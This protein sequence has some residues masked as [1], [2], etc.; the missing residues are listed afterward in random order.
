MLAAEQPVADLVGEDPAEGAADG[1][2]AG[3]GRQ[4]AD[5]PAE[6]RLALHRRRDR[7][8]RQLNQP[9]R[10]IRRD[11]DHAAEGVPAADAQVGVGPPGQVLAHHDQ[12]LVGPDRA[13]RRRSRPVEGDAGRR[14]DPRRFT[15]GLVQHHAA[16]AAAVDPDQR[17]R[18]VARGAAGS[19]ACAAAAVP[20]MDSP[21]AVSA[22]R[23]R[24][25]VRATC[26]LSS[27]R[28]T[29]PLVGKGV[30]IGLTS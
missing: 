12:H 26:S 7:R 9:A 15:L 20:V 10:A 4:V 30:K 27:G 11:E 2:L 5:R 21:S 22:S 18:G 13:G 1:Q 25:D 29:W 16:G 8:Q 28:A 24:T 17:Q 14:P 6:Q 19:G 23:R 3:R